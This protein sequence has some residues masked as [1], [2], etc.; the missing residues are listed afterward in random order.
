[1]ISVAI[2]KGDILGT[3]FTCKVTAVY[4]VKKQYRKENTKHP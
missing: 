1:M 3:I 2:S 4:G